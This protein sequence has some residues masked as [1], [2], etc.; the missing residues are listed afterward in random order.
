MKT[1]LPP[2]RGRYP[3]SEAEVAQLESVLLRISLRPDA[4]WLAGRIVTLLS[5]YYVAE[6]HPSAMEAIAKDW[7]KELADLPEWAINDACHWWVSRHNPKRAKRPLP[8]DISDRA[9]VE[10][11]IIDIGWKQVSNFK[12]YGAN[13]P[14]FL[15]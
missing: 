10:A 6:I 13:P 15:K 9:H 2:L 14:S 5:H 12:K 7:T 4:K 8:G 3:T 1:S 11:A